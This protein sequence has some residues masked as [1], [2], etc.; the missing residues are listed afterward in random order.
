M[1]A[2]SVFSNIAPADV[3][4]NRIRELEADNASLRNDLNRKDAV[5]SSLQARLEAAAP[6]DY[7]LD[8]V[9]I[10]GGQFESQYVMAPESVVVEATTQLRNRYAREFADLLES[11]HRFQMGSK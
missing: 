8:L 3:A 10:Y 11:E 5:I 4:A 6:S 7:E 1:N 9:E 2:L